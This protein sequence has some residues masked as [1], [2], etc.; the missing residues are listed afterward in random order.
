MLFDELQ[1]EIAASGLPA[2]PRVIKY[3]ESYVRDRGNHSVIT[4]MATELASIL[5]KDGEAITSEMLSGDYANML[6]VWDR[7]FSHVVTIQ[8]LTVAELAEFS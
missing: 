8:P 2:T 7:E 4:G 5:G 1:A 3:N 6:I